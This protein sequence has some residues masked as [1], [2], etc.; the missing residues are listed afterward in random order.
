VNDLLTPLA[1]V[2]IVFFGVA[3][4]FVAVYFVQ[5]ARDVVRLV[6]SGQVKVDVK[7]S[8]EPIE[9]FPELEEPEPDPAKPARDTP[10]GWGFDR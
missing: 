5:Q 2:G 6:K 4:V 7:W 8:N 1:I 9:P 3:L 10:A